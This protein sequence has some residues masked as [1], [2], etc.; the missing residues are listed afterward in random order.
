MKAE[1]AGNFQACGS[2]GSQLLQHLA[3]IGD[4]GRQAA[5]RSPLAERLDDAPHT[6]LRRMVIEKNAPAP[7]DL[8]VDKS[9]RQDR[10]GGKLD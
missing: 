4:Q 10:I 6:G 7:V 2:H 1:H 9:G 8:D 5:C 3:S